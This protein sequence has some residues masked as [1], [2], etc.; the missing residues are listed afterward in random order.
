MIRS[1]KLRSYTECIKNGLS[2]M[3]FI[4][5][6]RKPRPVLKV[7]ARLPTKARS[8][9]SAS[10]NVPSVSG[11]GW[12]ATVGPTWVRSVSSVT[13]SSTHINRWGFQTIVTFTDNIPFS[14]IITHWSLIFQFEWNPTRVLE[15]ALFA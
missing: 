2:L 8:D 14:N 10:T 5:F 1:Q 11:S 15:S 4:I 3:L 13:S 6:R 9:V 7:R 12:A